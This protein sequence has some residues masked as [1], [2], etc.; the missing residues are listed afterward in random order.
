M[1]HILNPG[2]FPQ[3]VI[4]NDRESTRRRLLGQAAAL[5][6]LLILPLLARPSAARAGNASKDDFHYQDHPNEEKRCAN[7]VQFI[8]AGDAQQP[9]ACKIVAGSISPNGWCMAFTP[10]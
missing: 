5:P 7:C 4:M 8:P 10:K 6:V 1:V 2:P 3:E 9:G